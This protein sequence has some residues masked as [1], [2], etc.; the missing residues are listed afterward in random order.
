MKNIINVI[1]DLF[2]LYPLP[3]ASLVYTSDFQPV[4]CQR[5]TGVPQGIL[6]PAI[7][8]YLVRALTSV[9]LDCQIEK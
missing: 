4:C 8:D 6:K 9:S 7:S 2:F 1:S 5:H 3:V